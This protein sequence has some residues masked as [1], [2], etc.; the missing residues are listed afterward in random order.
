MATV[1][2]NPSTSLHSGDRASSG[3]FLP[4][5]QVLTAATPTAWPAVLSSPLTCIRAALPSSGV[6]LTPQIATL[7]TAVGGVHRLPLVATPTVLG[8]ATGTSMPQIVGP[9][10]L[11]QTPST[12][13]SVPVISIQLPCVTTS[14]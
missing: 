13:A 11:T 2:L 3:G 12:T 1:A 6:M 8:L 7:P 9:L 5:Q 10:S 14:A 4:A